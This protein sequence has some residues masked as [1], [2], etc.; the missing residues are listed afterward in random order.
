MAIVQLIERVELSSSLWLTFW[1]LDRQRQI[2]LEIGRPSFAYQ[3]G[4]LYRLDSK[5]KNERAALRPILDPSE[6]GTLSPLIAV[7]AHGQAAAEPD[8]PPRHVSGEGNG[9]ARRVTA[10]STLRFVS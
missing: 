4:E 3:L 6:L 1:D 7:S 9:V 2:S 10:F 5:V 8:R